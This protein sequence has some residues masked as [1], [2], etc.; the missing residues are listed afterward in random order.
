MSSATV[1]LLEDDTLAFGD[2]DLEPGTPKGVLT[3]P[4]VTLFHLSFRGCAL[5]GYLFCRFFTDSFISSFITIVLL[6]SMD[7]WT[8]K[9]ITGRLMVGLRWWNYIDDDGKS[10]WVFESRKGLQQNRI[11]DR[12]AYIFWTALVLTPV[13]WSI[14]FLIA[15]F[16]FSVKWLLIVMIALVLSGSNLYGYLKCKMGSNESIT[17]VTTNFFR[18]QVLKSAVAMVSSQATTPFTNDPA[19]TI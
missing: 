5:F 12:E 1:P 6:L 13:I 15:F 2:E 9:N 8:V 17:N 18:N 11:N 7:F 14:L 4:Y 10:H 19:N 3:H 16:S